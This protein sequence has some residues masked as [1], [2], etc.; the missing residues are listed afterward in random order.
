MA[1]SQ[2]NISVWNGIWVLL[3]LACVTS[4]LVLVSIDSS[5]IDVDVDLV[6]IDYGRGRWASQLVCC[7]RFWSWAHQ[8]LIVSN[9]AAPPE[10]STF[11]A[12][13]IQWIQ[14]NDDL[15][16]DTTLQSV[17]AKLDADGTRSPYMVCLND[18]VYP[19]KSI[20][21][22]VMLP[23]RFFNGWLDPQWQHWLLG[24]IQNR[25]ELPQPEPTLPVLVSKWTSWTEKT[26]TKRFIDDS[27]VVD[28][29]CLIWK[30]NLNWSVWIDTTDSVT[31]LIQ[32]IQTH[33]TRAPFLTIHITSNSTL[34]QIW[35]DQ[36][37]TLWDVQHFQPVS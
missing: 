25:T 27:L 24:P 5:D 4:I 11:Q 37:N 16:Q 36:W 10:F 31:Q 28:Q 3:I 12:K 8:F 14:I 9:Q 33:Q 20:K 22:H 18:Q 17:M 1:F 2:W 30:P 6:L 29:S 15:L 32:T 26:W 13:H 7:S 21:R 23:G 35:L 34:E 19:I